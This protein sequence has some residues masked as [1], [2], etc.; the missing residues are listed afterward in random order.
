MGNGTTW[1]FPVLY[2]VVQGATPAKVVLEGASGLLP[3]LPPRL[4]TW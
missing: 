2:R 1:P 3:A 4:V